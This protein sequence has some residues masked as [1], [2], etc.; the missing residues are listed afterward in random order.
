[1]RA[2]IET[3]GA[4]LKIAPAPLAALR[5]AMPHPNAALVARFYDAFA[6]R[7]ADAM[8]ACYHPDVHFQD[9]VFD[10]HGPRAGAMWRMLCAGG[11]DLA[12]TASEI[13][14]D[15]ATGSARWVATYTFSQTGRRVRNEVEAA[16]TFEDGLIRTHR[17]RFPFWTWAR[18][19]LG[20]PGLLLGWTPFLK[21]AVRTRA[22]RQLARY[23]DTHPEA[24]G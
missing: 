8:A 22:A 1:V 5:S 3:W 18:Q 19:A 24:L 15:D 13:E 2:D 21:T 4:P 9:E 14:A 23:V 17:D 16:F 20:L 7:D 12:I 10:L 11:T 6:R